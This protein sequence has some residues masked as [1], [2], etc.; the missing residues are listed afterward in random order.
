MQ[1]IDAYPV[2]YHMTGD[3]INS[4]VKDCAFYRSFYRCVTIHQTNKV[5]VSENVAFD[6]TGARSL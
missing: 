4:F 5:T 6:I 2:H 1:I 3:N